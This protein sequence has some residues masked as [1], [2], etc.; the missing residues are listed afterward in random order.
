MT[1][2]LFFQ[3]IIFGFLPFKFDKK[4]QRIVISKAVRVFNLILI[5]LFIINYVPFTLQS[6]QMIMREFEN[7]KRTVSIVYNLVAFFFTIFSYIFIGKHQKE[8]AQILN[9]F[10]KLCPVLMKSENNI[11]IFSKLLIFQCFFL[12]PCLFLF[13]CWL[14]V[15]TLLN[16]FEK[17]YLYTL[18]YFFMFPTRLISIFV[19]LLLNF[20]SILLQKAPNTQ[21]DDNIYAV[22]NLTRTILDLFNPYVCVYICCHFFSYSRIQFWDIC[23]CFGHNTRNFS[24][25]TSCSFCLFVFIFT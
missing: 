24:E 20:H 7:T 9:Q 16:N 5:I 15:P 4:L 18:Q 1:K 13:N 2:V 3:G 25:I 21:T 10:I 8:I 17:S 11:K 23:I 12:Q 6:F 22:L 14:L 19:C